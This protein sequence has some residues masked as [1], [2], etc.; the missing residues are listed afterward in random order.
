MPGQV[1]DQGAPAHQQVARTQ[2]AARALA[3]ARERGRKTLRSAGT[4][5]LTLKVAKKA[6][7]RF[8]RVR[9]ATV[10]LRVTR[11]GAPTL[12]RKLKLKR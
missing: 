9:K 5:T 1:H 10:T 3:P 11:T 8:R 6:K 7:K 4:T 12:S 2:A